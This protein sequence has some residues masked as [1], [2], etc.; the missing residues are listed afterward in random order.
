MMIEAAHQVSS[1]GSPVHQVPG[2]GHQGGTCYGQALF[3]RL[4]RGRRRVVLV[5]INWRRNMDWIMFVVVNRRRRRRGR[6]GRMMLMI[7]RSVVVWLVV[8]W[9]V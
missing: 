8:L 3:S 5:M 9:F 6:R 2:L 1:H 4:G 7:Y